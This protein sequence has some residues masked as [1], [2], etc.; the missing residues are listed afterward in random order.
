MGCHTSRADAEEQLAALY[1]NEPSAKKQI[2]TMLKQALRLFEFAVLTEHPLTGIDA[3]A[4]LSAAAPVPAADVATDSAADSA[5]DVDFYPPT[6]RHAEPPP[7][8]EERDGE[9]MPVA[10]KMPLP[11]EAELQG[12]FLAGLANI[13]KAQNKTVRGV[14]HP[15]SDFAIVRDPAKPATWAILLS[16]NQVGVFTYE[17]LR[18]A[19]ILLTPGTQVFKALGLSPEELTSAMRRIRAELRKLNV[20]VA[21]WPASVRKSLDVSGER[22]FAVFSNNCIDNDYPPDIFSLRA[23]KAYAYLV[24]QGVI[25][26]P[27]LWVWHLPGTAIGRADVVDVT[28]DGFIYAA[29]SA[30]PGQEDKLRKLA[31][32][33]SDWGVSHSAPLRTVIRRPSDRRVIDFYIS[34]EVSVLPRG[35]EANP[36]T[37]FHVKKEQHVMPLTDEMRAAL[38]EIGY[39]AAEIAQIDDVIEKHAAL[40]EAREKKE[41]DE[42]PPAGETP[43]TVAP[44]VDTSNFVTRQDME[45]L[46]QTQADMIREL[47]TGLADVVG[48][49][50]QLKESDDEKVAK[51]AQ[52]TPRASLAE[53]MQQFVVG[54]P[55]A[56][57]D[58]RSSLAKA[59]PKEQPAKAQRGLT[60]VEFIDNLIA[61][62]AE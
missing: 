16:A 3:P 27:E 7:S 29:G 19:A 24:K 45:T 49:V 22:W 28:E 8:G 34:T 37:S 31:A 47:R 15:A 52:M 4:S 57:V 53:L 18:R 36:L 33:G 1:A 50:K 59:G 13:E 2:T 20:D 23:H 51:A 38:G 26:P 10:A 30:Y 58:G 17:S 48:V 43:P 5:A 62:P 25:A 21:R 42:E 40:A 61:P 55:A 35:K 14:A 39:E 54:Q 56:Q 32:L 11:S 41:Q 9:S 6:G 44:V 46:I 60:G 12:D